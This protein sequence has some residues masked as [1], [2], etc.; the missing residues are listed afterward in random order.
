[1]NLPRLRMVETL[2]FVSGTWLLV[3]DET[4]EISRRFDDVCM[5]ILDV[6]DD[7]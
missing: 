1:M 3:C 6:I 2:M 5:K 4:V 7:I